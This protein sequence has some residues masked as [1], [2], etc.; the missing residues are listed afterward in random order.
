M[1]RQ[2][3]EMLGEFWTIDLLLRKRSRVEDSVTAYGDAL[4]NVRVTPTPNE[5]GGM[6]PPTFVGDRTYERVREAHTALR[7]ALRGELDRL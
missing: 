7:E 2:R 3:Y 1:R 6:E 4:E 5:Q